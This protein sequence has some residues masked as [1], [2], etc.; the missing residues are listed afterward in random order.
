M[1]V[2][3]GAAARNVAKNLPQYHLISVVGGLVCG[4]AGLLVSYYVG[5][6]TGASITLLLSLWFFVTLL[7]KKAH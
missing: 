1:L 7:F 5:A 3:P 6:S 2:L 4:V